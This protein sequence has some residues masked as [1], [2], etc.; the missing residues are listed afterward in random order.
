MLKV[1]CSLFNVKNLLFSVHGSLRSFLSPQCQCYLGGWCLGVGGV[2]ADG[3]T[4]VGGG[5]AI[6]CWG[7]TVASGVGVSGIG[8][9]GALIADFG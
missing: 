5:L 8:Q 2:K 3:L 9:G 6:V 4:G 7:P 1:L